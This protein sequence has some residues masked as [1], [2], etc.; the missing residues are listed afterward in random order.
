[1]S[2]LILASASPRRHQLLAQLGV[3]FQVDAAAIDEAVDPGEKPLAYVTR[4]A[5][6]KAAAVAARRGD[7]AAVL[8]ADTSV[9]ID[10]DVLGKPT[11]HFQGLGM[12]ARLSGR[13]HSVITAVCLL[14][15]SRV[16]CC[17]VETRV[18]FVNLSREI[19]ERYL[20]TGESWDKAGGYAIQGLGGALVSSI[21]GSYSNVV[22]LPLAE[23]WQLLAEHGIET[24]LGGWS[25]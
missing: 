4:M 20:A 9:I 22:G 24:A 2:S 5:R 3:G 7:G 16:A 12:L 8:A 17:E 25:E 1:M 23:T 6:Q 13:T 21:E 18:G 11:D 15:G 14:Q 19:C 10:G